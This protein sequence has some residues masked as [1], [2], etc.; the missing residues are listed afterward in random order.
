MHIT[1][2]INREPQPLKVLARSDAQLEQF[3]HRYSTHCERII[4]PND[5]PSSGNV[6]LLPFWDDKLK[7]FERNEIK[8]S[9]AQFVVN[10]GKLI[11]VA[12]DEV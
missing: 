4:A 6:Y 10:G 9:I 1:V 3:E 12:S 8:F 5:F 2:R 11:K 7:E